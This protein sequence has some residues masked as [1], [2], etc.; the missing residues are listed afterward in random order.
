MIQILLNI[1]S[2]IIGA[3]IGWWFPWLDK[4]AYIFILHPEAQI[5]Q[6]I[7]FQL[8]KKNWKN[9][10][11]TLQVRDS[12]FDKLTTRGILFQLVWVVLAIFA[13]TSTGPLLGKSLVLALGLRILFEEWSEWLKDKTT[14]KQRLFWQIQGEWSDLELKIYLII[15][16]LI[17]AWLIRL[18]F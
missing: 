3:G 10:W 16:T 14:L 15:K 5:S 17:M 4:I 2:V 12:E 8:E 6:Y 7:K 11:E 9:A 18:M 13:L 1:L